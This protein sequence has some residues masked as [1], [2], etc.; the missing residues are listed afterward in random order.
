MTT[1]LSNKYTRWY[2]SIVS[3]ARSRVLTSYVEVHHIIPKSVGGTNKKLNL[4]QLTG[5]EHFICHWLLTKMLDNPRD[6]SKMHAALR[7]MLSSSS[8]HKDRYVPQS[9]SRVYEMLRTRI[10]KETSGEFSPRYGKPN[11][12][13]TRKKIGDK[14]RGK[15]IPA[16]V[17]LQIA[18]TL[19]EVSARK[20]KIEYDDGRTETVLNLKQWCK[21]RNIIVSSLRNTM[22]YGTFY[23]GMKVSKLE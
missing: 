10:A 11:S 23:N 12:P 9:N 22:S 18:R 15:V 5:R 20:W 3:R 14:N 8:K 16:E 13:E 21:D 17:R 7:Y 2:F 4:V 19:R 1:F 6:R